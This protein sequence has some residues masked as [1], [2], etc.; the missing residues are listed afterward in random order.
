[1]VGVDE[2]LTYHLEKEYKSQTQ[3]LFPEDLAAT[4]K[5]MT[6]AYGYTPAMAF[7]NCGPY[8]GAR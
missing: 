3:P 8:S 5:C 7:Y 6:T 2:G 4:W 1:M